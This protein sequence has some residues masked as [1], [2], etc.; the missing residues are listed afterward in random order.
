MRRVLRRGEHV[1]EI[2]FNERFKQRVEDAEQVAPLAHR[3]ACGAGRAD[4]G[5]GGRGDGGVERAQVRED[6]GGER[7]EEEGDWREDRGFELE[8]E[9][10]D[11]RDELDELFCVGAA[12]QLRQ[13]AREYP[14]KL[15]AERLSH[16]VQQHDALGTHLRRLSKRAHRGDHRLR[17]A[18]E[19]VAQHVRALVV[20]AHVDEPLA[21]ESDRRD[22]VRRLDLARTSQL[23][24]HLSR[25]AR[26]QPG[27]YALRSPL[28][29]RLQMRHRKRE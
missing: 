26:A 17:R 13:R 8:H 12:E 19:G 6:G 25:E 15:D 11:E 10:V 23:A 5:G 18:R 3:L 16:P 28:R 9:L 29:E 27:R 24:Y 21:R 20:D 22:V 14:Q 2:R 1:H 7:A 4:R